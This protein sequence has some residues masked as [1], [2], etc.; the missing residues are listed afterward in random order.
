[1]SQVFLLE[2]QRY[3]D[4]VSCRALGAEVP[5]TPSRTTEANLDCAFVENAHLFIVLKFGKALAP[6]HYRVYWLLIQ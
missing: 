4:T 6:L 5:G 1:M 3:T 2:L